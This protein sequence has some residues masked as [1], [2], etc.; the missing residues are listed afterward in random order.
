M[1]KG[2]MIDGGRL[3]EEKNPTVMFPAIVCIRTRDGSTDFLRGGGRSRIW[4][5]EGVD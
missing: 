3:P 5:K 4:M 2:W 1:C